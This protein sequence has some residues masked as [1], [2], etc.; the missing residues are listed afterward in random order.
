GGRTMCRRNITVLLAAVLTCWASASGFGQE[1]TKENTEPILE[2]A[3]DADTV[4]IML[5]QVG[6][7]RDEVPLLRIYGDGRVLVH[8]Q[9]VGDYE[10]YLSSQEIDVWLR[11]LYDLG[12]LKFDQAGI[13]RAARE[14]HDARNAEAAARGKPLRAFNSLIDVGPTIIEVRLK[15]FKPSGAGAQRVDNYTH[16]IAWTALR[17][18]ANKFPEVSDLSAFADAADELV[19]LIRHPDLVRIDEE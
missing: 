15:A 4:V 7:F 14:V 13:K 2:Y 19:D 5:D 9:T 3:R 16:R 12:V 17:R 8:R 18:S 1:Q 11:Y 6:A 10:M